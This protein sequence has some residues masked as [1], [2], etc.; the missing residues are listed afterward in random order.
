MVLNGVGQKILM[1][2]RMDIVM[3]TAIIINIHI[4]MATVMDIHQMKKNHNFIIL[5]INTYF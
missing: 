4:I 2:I 1:D 5:S 3:A